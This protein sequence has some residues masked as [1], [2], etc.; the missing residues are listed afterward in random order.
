[1]LEC[2]MLSEILV[3]TEEKKSLSELAI[4]VLSEVVMPLLEISVIAVLVELRL[5]ASLSI[6]QVFFGSFTEFARLFS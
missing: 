1:M 5:A 2:G 4:S 3:P 6:C